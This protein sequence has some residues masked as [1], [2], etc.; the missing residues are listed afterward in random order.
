MRKT[1]PFLL[2]VV[3]SL[4]IAAPALAD[5]MLLPLPE[6]LSPDYLAVRYHHVTVNIEDAHEA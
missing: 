4:S 1:I 3:L 5:G 6:T 2:T